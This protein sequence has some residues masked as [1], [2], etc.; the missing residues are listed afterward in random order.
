MGQRIETL[1]DGVTLILGD[2]R[3]VLP[4]LARH[5]ACVTDLPYGIG[6]T[7]GGTINAPKQKGAYNQLPDT[8]ENLRA[9][10]A[11]ALP[12]ILDVAGRVAVTPGRTNIGLY[13]QPKDIGIFYQPAATSMSYWGRATWQPILYYGR[14][15]RI[16][17]TIV[18]LHYVLTERPEKNGHP[19]PKPIGAWTWLVDRA[20]LPGETVLDPFMG[21]G[22]T[23]V[24]CVKLGRRFTGIEIDPEYFEIALRRVEDALREPSMFGDAA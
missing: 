8:R 24:A 3:E 6:E 23:G 4:T 10:V 21:S 12:L 2:C 11:T 5:D 16:G 1:A 15:P 9:L 19:C 18:P 14:D 22:T 20:S 13:P 17:K 7:T